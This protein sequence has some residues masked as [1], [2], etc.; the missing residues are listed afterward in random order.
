MECKNFM[1]MKKAPLFY[2]VIKLMKPLLYQRLVR[3]EELREV[4]VSYCFVQRIKLI[5][6]RTSGEPLM[7]ISNRHN[8]KPFSKSPPAS[9]LNCI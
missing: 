6:L 3:D 2:L 5:L 4:S 9:L 7:S 8:H 1:K